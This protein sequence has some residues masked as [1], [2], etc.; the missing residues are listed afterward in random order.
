M[1]K[2][3]RITVETWDECQTI[4]YE[5]SKLKRNPT[6]VIAQRVSHQLQG[7]NLRRVTVDAL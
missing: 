4:W 5:S 2:Q 6:D 7:L 1:T 3:Y